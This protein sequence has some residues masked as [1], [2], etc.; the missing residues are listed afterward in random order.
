[1]HRLKEEMLRIALRDL[2]QILF[3]DAVEN[4]RLDIS[5]LQGM[6]QKAEQLQERLQE[7]ADSL[8]VFLDHFSIRVDMTLLRRQAK[9]KKQ[10][11]VEAMAALLRLIAEELEAPLAGGAHGKLNHYILEGEE[12]EFFQNSG[13]GFCVLKNWEKQ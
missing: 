9:D 10:T 12:R 6:W 13:T 1:M 2:H 7:Q 11:E 8:D 3:D 4:P 5:E